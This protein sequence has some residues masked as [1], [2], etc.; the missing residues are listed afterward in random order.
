MLGFTLKGINIAMDMHIFR[1]HPSETKTETDI[2][3]RSAPDINT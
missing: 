2:S 3:V 1:F